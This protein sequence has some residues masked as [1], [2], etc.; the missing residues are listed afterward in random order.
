M[1]AALASKLAAQHKNFS[2]DKDA[3]DWVHPSSLHPYWLPS[4]DIHIC[5]GWYGMMIWC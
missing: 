5:Y 3:V 4:S 1:L 2:S